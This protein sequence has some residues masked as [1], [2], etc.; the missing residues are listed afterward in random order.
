MSII[1]GQRNTSGPVGGNP[2]LGAIGLLAMGI[3]LWVLACAAAVTLS[4][5]SLLLDLSLHGGPAGI[6]QNVLMSGVAGIFAGVA[7]AIVR[8]WPRKTSALTKSFISALF[9]KGLAEPQLDA[10]FWG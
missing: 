9:S 4:G 5:L 7:M 2:I 6:I 3:S 10:V 8:C 1:S